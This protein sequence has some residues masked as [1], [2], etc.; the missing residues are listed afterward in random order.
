MLSVN[1]PA[2]RMRL[3]RF[4]KPSVALARCQETA[5]GPAPNQS[6]YEPLFHSASEVLTNYRALLGVKK[7][8]PEE[9]EKINAVSKPVAPQKSKMMRP[10]QPQK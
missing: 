7:V 9:L 1:T 4:G 8:V 3:E 2:S 5:A 6:I 10:T